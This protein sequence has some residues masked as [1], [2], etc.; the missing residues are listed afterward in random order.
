[1]TENNQKDYI[2][3]CVNEAYAM[4]MERERK[5]IMHKIEMHNKKRNEN[6]KSRKNER[7]NRKKGRS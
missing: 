1:M 3:Q 5:K 4:S 2:Q 7:Q 6:K